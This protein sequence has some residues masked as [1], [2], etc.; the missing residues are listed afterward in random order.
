MTT[1]LLDTDLSIAAFGEDESGEIYLAH[2]SS[3]N[4]TI[5]RISE[6]A[7]P[8]PLESSGGGG[9]GCFISALAD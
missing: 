8:A 2:F 1:E 4:G 5:Y 3:G 7:D 9:G 6:I